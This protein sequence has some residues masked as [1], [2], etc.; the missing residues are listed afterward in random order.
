MMPECDILYFNI[1][2]D[3]WTNKPVLEKYV[4]NDRD[5]KAGSEFPFKRLPS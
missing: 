3:E 2:S 5:I 1:E 4:I